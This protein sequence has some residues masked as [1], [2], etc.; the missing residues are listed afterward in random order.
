MLNFTK[1][2]RQQN[3]DVE[4]GEPPAPQKPFINGFPSAAE[5]IAS[6]P[7]HSFSIYRAFHQLTSRNLLHLEAELLELQKQQNDMDI[8]DFRG[9][10]DTVQSLR[11]WKKLSTSTSGRPTARM[12]LTWKIQRTL[13]EYR[14]SPG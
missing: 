8:E 1:R 3:A 14:K 6:D 12:E 13:K 7:D 10:P 2:R 5:F 9:N 11:S 4:T